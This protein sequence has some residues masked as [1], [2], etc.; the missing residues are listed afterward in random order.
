MV[1]FIFFLMEVS[2]RGSLLSHCQLQPETIGKLSSVTGELARALQLLG[3][4]AK[5]MDRV[6]ENKE[7]RGNTSD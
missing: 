6:G 4:D 7:H 5:E 2:S 3:G 1:L